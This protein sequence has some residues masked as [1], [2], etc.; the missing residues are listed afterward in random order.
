MDTMIVVDCDLRN[1][2]GYVVLSDASEFDIVLDW[3]GLHIRAPSGDRDI[4]DPVIHDAVQSQLVR[5]CL[6]DS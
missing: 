2:R 3:A 6:L 5:E 4:T 1:G